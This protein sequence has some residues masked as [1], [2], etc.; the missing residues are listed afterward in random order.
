MENIEEFKKEYSDLLLSHSFQDQLISRGRKD[1]EIEYTLNKME[2]FPFDVNHVREQNLDASIISHLA[3]N[4]NLQ[5][6]HTCQRVAKYNEISGLFL[7]ADDFQSN[8][9][10]FTDFQKCS[11]KIKELIHNFDQISFFEL[12]QTSP[13]NRP[14]EKQF[15]E[16][17]I[18]N[19]KTLLNLEKELAYMNGPQ[20]LKCLGLLL[21]LTEEELKKTKEGLT[22]QDS[23]FMA[24]VYNLNYVF[25]ADNYW[26]KEKDKFRNH[27]KRNELMDDV[28][29][30]GLTTYYRQLLSDFK[31]NDVGRIWQKHSEEESELAY[32][33]YNLPINIEQ[34]E[35]YFEYIFK[36]EEIKRWVSELKNPT[37]LKVTS[38]SAIEGGDVSE[39]A[40]NLKIVSLFEDNTLKADEP[41]RLYF[42]L[43][44]MWARQLLDNKEIPAF[45][46]KVG[47]AYPALFTEERTQ[48]TIITSL[49]NM[50]RKSNKYFDVFVRN[51]ATM[52]EY[53]DTMYPTRANGERRKEGE[54][55]VSLA[56]KLFLALKL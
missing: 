37:T 9:D 20:L 53:I 14:L 6:S 38:N 55:A 56:N 26:K 49:Q 31:T 18:I 22:Y 24:L 43:L 25:Y 54:F 3:Y 11:S 2:N 28:T 50:N 46:R 10:H 4:L 40:L 15:S 29:V 7:V 5:L 47:K 52:V 44:A 8:Y 51:Q 12:Y 1:I 27:V 30:E 19:K 16:E 36:I 48:E 13:N 21:D 41:S 23:N 35:Y 32:E 39:D 45:V 34:W 33:L 17:L 42:L